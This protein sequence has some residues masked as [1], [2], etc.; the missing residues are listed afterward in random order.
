MQ[1]VKV[2]KKYRVLL[3]AIFLAHN[4]AHGETVVITNLKNPEALKPVAIRQIFLGKSQTFPSGTLAMP[5]ES[6][7]SQKDFSEKFLQ[8]TPESLNAYWA[9]LLFTGTAKPLK[10]LDSDDE[11]LRFVLNNPNAIGYIDSSKVTSAVKVVSQ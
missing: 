9:R 2:I 7:T 6:A 1:T 3:G 11:V 10:K 8:M 5:V 4:L